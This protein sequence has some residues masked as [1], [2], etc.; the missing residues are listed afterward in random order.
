MILVPYSAIVSQLKTARTSIIVSSCLYLQYWLD[1]LHRCLLLHLHCGL[2]DE[3]YCVFRENVLSLQASSTPCFKGRRCID[4]EVPELLESVTSDNGE[5][6][7][8]V[9][10]CP[11]VHRSFNTCSNLS[12]LGTM[13]SLSQRGQDTTRSMSSSISLK[14]V[15]P[16]V[17]PLKADGSA[18]HHCCHQNGWPSRNGTHNYQ[19]KWYGVQQSFLCPP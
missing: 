13:M 3:K 14:N 2:S 5:E 9:L 11:P 15:A 12:S 6:Y 17:N 7:G 10:I 18:P 4:R 8:K 16:Q 1:C 19:F